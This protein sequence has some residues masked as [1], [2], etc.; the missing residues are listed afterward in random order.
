MT[1]FS[2]AAARSHFRTAMCWVLAAA[3]A[4][5]LGADIGNLGPTYPVQEQNLL[6]MIEQRLLARAE[7]GEMSRLMEQ[8][9]ATARATVASPT[10]VAGLAACSKARSFYF[11]PSMMLAENVFDGTGR[12]M[13]AAGTRK[14]PLD[15]ITLS[16]AL[17]FFDA[18]D[19]RQRGQAQRMLR[20]H[21]P[22]LKL[23]LTGGSYLDLM[24]QW[25]MPI[26]YD[27]Q[28]LLTRRLGIRQVPALVTQEG[29]RLRI[30]EME[31]SP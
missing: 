24:R 3:P 4:L 26:Y 28:G 25:R 12:L 19:A 5:C 31:V 16:R 17:L 15:V 20:E 21:G 14:N 9:A 30:D 23:I 7:S 6:A 29:L 8:A 27:Q 1:M 2:P 18:R 22:R 10:P 13:F 11:D